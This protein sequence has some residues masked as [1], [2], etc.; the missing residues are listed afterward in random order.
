[1]APKS[2][3]I[4]DVRFDAAERRY[5]GAVIFYETNGMEVMQVST[6]GAPTWGYA[7]TLEA[8]RLAGQRARFSR[9]AD[10]AV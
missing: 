10:P 8:L 3:R 6:P 4:Q 5:H 7:R 9:T 1:M 2:M